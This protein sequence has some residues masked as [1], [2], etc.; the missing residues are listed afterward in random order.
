MILAGEILLVI[1]VLA[2]MV[3]TYACLE[4][5][6]GKETAFARHYIKSPAATITY[7]LIGVSVIL[8]LINLSRFYLLL[9]PLCAVFAWACWHNW[10]ILHGQK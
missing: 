10:R 2:D 7:T 5:G 6:K 3:I 4:S 1:L 9:A 8:S